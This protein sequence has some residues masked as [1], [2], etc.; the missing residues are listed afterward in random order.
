CSNLDC[1]LQAQRIRRPT[2]QHFELASIDG[3]V[4]KGNIVIGKIALTQFELDDLLFS[5]FESDFRKCLEFLFRP[6]RLRALFTDVELYDLFARDSTGI[7]DSDRHAQAFRLPHRGR[8]QP[9]VRIIECCIAKTESK[10]EQRSDIPDVV[11]AVANKN[12]FSI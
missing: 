11:I 8:V 3:P 5:W 1:L 7:P 12:S 10:R 6:H 2:D 9:E 4:L